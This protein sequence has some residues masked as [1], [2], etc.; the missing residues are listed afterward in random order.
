MLNWLGWAAACGWAAGCGGGTGCGAGAAGVACCL[1]R[2]LGWLGWANVFDWGWRLGC[3]QL[4]GAGLR[5]WL[6]GDGAPAVAWA[7]GAVGGCCQKLGAS[8]AGWVG[9]MLSL[10]LAPG[11]GCH[12]SQG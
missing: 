1:G 9:L 5:W 8:R 11:M 4:A 6:W 3:W 7:G 12:A 10:W 2:G